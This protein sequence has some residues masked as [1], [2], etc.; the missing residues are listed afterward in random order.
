MSAPMRVTRIFSA[1]VWS[2]TDMN[3][4]GLACRSSCAACAACALSMA[5]WMPSSVST[6]PPP[7]QPVERSFQRMTAMGKRSSS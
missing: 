3:V 1:D 6:S 5:C 7:A 2:W 4:T